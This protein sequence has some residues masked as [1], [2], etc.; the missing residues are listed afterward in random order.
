MTGHGRPED[1]SFLQGQVVSASDPFTATTSF[2]K[3]A[4]SNIILSVGGS[5]VVSLGAGQTIQFRLNNRTGKAMAAAPG[6]DLN[7]FSIYALT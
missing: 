1:D 3:E 4:G 2:T 7:V 5:N 6:A